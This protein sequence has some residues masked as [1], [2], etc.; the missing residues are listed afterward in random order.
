MPRDFLENL[1]RPI[2]VLTVY[3]PVIGLMVTP[4]EDPSGREASRDPGRHAPFAWDDDEKAARPFFAQ[5]AQ[6]TH[7]GRQIGQ[8]LQNV[9]SNDAVEVPVGKIQPC[10]AIRQPGLH[11]WEPLPQVCQ[12][13]LSEVHG[14]VVCLLL[15][16]Q[17]L[18]GEVFPQAG[19]NFQ[20]GAE[21]F[22]GMLYPV[23]LIELINEAIPARENLMPVPHEIVADPLL[24]RSQWR[25]LLGPFAHVLV[26]GPPPPA[27]RG[28]ARPADTRGADPFRFRFHVQGRTPGPWKSARRKPDLPPHCPL[29]PASC[30]ESGEVAADVKGF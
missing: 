19:A 7:R 3:E 2:Y 26:G 5:P 24:F 15:R 18:V 17:A 21:G 12:H 10:L 1:A 30:G 4:L 27:K 28:L 22:G 11:S 23:A 8:M 13:V 25:E 14:D 20:G 6:F 16:C 9:N 29:C